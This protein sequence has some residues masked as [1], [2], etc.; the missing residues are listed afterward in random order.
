MKHGTLVDMALT[1]F[2]VAFAV[3][4]TLPMIISVIDNLLLL[5]R[6]LS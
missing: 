2:M 5:I 4:V 3:I 6:E 1:I